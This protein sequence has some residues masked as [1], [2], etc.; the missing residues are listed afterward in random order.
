MKKSL[1]TNQL[2]KEYCRRSFYNFFKLF[3]SQV[4]SSEFTDNYHIKLICD[5]LQCRFK[6]FNTSKDISINQDRLYDLLINCPPGSSKSLIISVFFPAWCW[7][8]RPSTKLITASYSHTIAEELSGKSLRLIQSDLYQDLV[9]FKLTSQAVNNIKNDKGGQRYV[10][11]IKGSVTGVHADIIICDDI[12]SPQ[13]IYSEA[14]REQSRKFI[15]EIL[16]SRKT[17]PKKSYNIYVQQR[18]H[19]DDAT[20]ILSRSSKKIKYIKIPAINDNGESFFPSRFSLE[21]LNDMK[22]QLGTISFNAQYL[23]I[24]QD[25]DGGI[26]KKNWLKES[27]TEDKQLTY[28]I[29][30]AYG[31]K[32]ADYNAIIGCYK[33]QNNLIIQMC[34]INKLEFPELI[35]WLKSNLPNNAKIYIEGKASGKSII[36]TLKQQTNF[37]IIETQPKGS[38]LE[39][40]NAVAPY[41]EG[42]RVIINQYINFKQ[43]MV[44][45]LIFDNT[46]H[47]DI[48]DV[49]CNAIETLLKVSNGKYN[50]K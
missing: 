19:N 22:E 1:I 28:F 49:I 15:N 14:D 27:V 5:E 47:D 4:E 29:D 20:G 41:F 12:N 33:E 44:E 11:S 17:N 7:L 32:D 18:L 23:Q 38:K 10:T 39:R 6:T 8:N 31:G 3:W 43:D 16:P 25:A 2:I 34:E 9:D 24:T 35:K 42:G 48:M 26:I 37:N 13:S 50:I 40:K 36:Q 21:F 45:Q 46:K 30:S